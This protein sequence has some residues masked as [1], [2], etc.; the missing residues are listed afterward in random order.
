M[1]KG[2]Y[3]PLLMILL[4]I[5][6]FALGSLYT[7]VQY[8]EQGGSQAAKTK[9]SAGTSVSSTGLT[10]TFSS[11]AKQLKL[12]T[13]VFSQCLAK[14][15]YKAKVE[16]ELQEGIGAGVRGTPG[17]FVNGKFVAGAFPF[18]AFQDIID[19]ELNGTSST[20]YKDYAVILQ[21]AY[22]EGK[23]FDPQPKQIPIGKDTP[24]RGSSNAQV[25]IV[26]YSDFQCPF[27]SRALPTVNQIMSQYQ[28]KV[29]LAYKHYPLKEIHPNA[30]KAAEA[31]ECARE[32]NKF[33][34]YHDLLFQNQQAWS[35]LSQNS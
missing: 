33:W 23:A 13:T 9:D 32:Q 7:K 30:Q 10:Q 34:E 26:E 4:L 31:S 2:L 20:N 35:P 12:N 25:T 24:I 6:S 3:I 14:E 19:K 15:K 27:C 29:Q 16:A 22:E 11:Y 5:A 21:Q 18:E 8:L 17:F 28:G 1:N